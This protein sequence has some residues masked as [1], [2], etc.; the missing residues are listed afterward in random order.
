M[1]RILHWALIL[2]VAGAPLPFAAN[3]PWAW[4]LLAVAVAVLLV[5]WV[6]SAL[7]EP[8]RVRMGWKHHGWAT[9]L[10]C[11]TLLWTAIQ[12]VGW[13]PASMHHPLWQDAAIALGQPLNG[14][15]ALDGA[16][17]GETIMRLLTYA[18][19]FWLSLHLGREPRRARR[20]LIV[21]AAAGT[22]YAGYGLY[23]H[24]SG[25]NSIFWFERWAYQG[26]VTSTFVNRNS[27]A[28][29]AG[30]VIICII[31][32][33]FRPDEDIRSENPL[34]RRGIAEMLA[35]FATGGWYY[36]G[37]LAV[38]GLALVLSHSRAGLA[39]AG[40][41]MLVLLATQRIGKRISTGATLVYGGVAALAAALLIVLA[42][43]NADGLDRSVDGE[44]GA[45]FAQSQEAIAERPLLGTGLGSYPDVFLTHR[46][47]E[48]RTLQ[49]K[50]HSTYLEFAIEAGLPAT[51]LM[52]ITIGGLGVI[53]VMGARRR[54]RYG[55]YPASAAAATALVAA[56]SIVDFSLQIPAVSVTFAAILGVGIAQSWRRRSRDRRQLESPDSTDDD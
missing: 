14:A 12:T 42:G 4:N 37:A 24:L 2:I 40:L 10:F 33:L 19:V 5:F 51:I 27:F 45:L 55:G 47:A 13:T 7:R 54:R 49:D 31:T 28:T 11:L 52:V 25:S 17:A 18:G 23:S 48:T 35:G 53:C 50:A 9:G 44:R 6:V 20:M 26:S 56:H 1:S 43:P 39:A 15:I 34:S 41:G 3:R 16:R 38:T 30:L 29:Y 21:I 8:A 36:L 46:T 22:A 32:L